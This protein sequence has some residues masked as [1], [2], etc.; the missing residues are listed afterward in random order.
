MSRH[1]KTIE[2]DL[3]SKVKSAVRDQSKFE[4]MR[5]A[6]KTNI[7]SQDTCR[8]K[9]E[10]FESRREMAR[11]SR[12]KVLGDPF[13]LQRTV[14]RLKANRIKV[15]GPCP[16]EE[17]L[18]AVYKELDGEKLV[19]KSK[20]NIT[21]EIG[22]T[23]FLESKG[24]EVIET[25]VGDR[26]IQIAGERTIHP[27][28]PAVHLTRYDIAKILRKHFGR[29]I[30]PDP[31]GLTEAIREEVSDYIM[32][33]KVGVTGANFITAEEGAFVI[34][35]N[36]GNVSL[37]ARR[38]EKH[39]VVS[40]E[41]K[42]VPNLD[43]AM[44]LV[45][46]QTFYGTGSINSSFVDVIAGPSRTADI[47][48]KTFYG[49]HGPKDI[50]LVLVDNGRGLIEDKEIMYCINCGG[51]LL[52]CPVYDLM[53][54][55]FGGHA[56]LGGRGVC[57]TAETESIED[58]SA[59]G[60][61]L[62]TNCGVCTE[63]CP[64]NIDTARIM[65]NTRK[66]ALSAGCLPTEEQRSTLANIRKHGNPW[67]EPRGNRARWAEDLRLPKK[68]ET[69]YF[70][71]CFPS[72]RAPEV[73]KATV[74]VLKAGGVAVAYLGGLESCCGS[75]A[76][77]M[78]DEDLFRKLADQNF[79]EMKRARVKKI[80]TSCAGCYNM[81]SS[82][83]DFIPGF[84]IEVEHITSTL[85]RLVEEGRIKFHSWKAD[86]TY[87]DPCDLG[88]HRGIYEEP[89]S[90]LRAIPDLRIIEMPSNRN[91]SMCCGAGAGVK[92]AYPYL[93]ET[94]AGKRIEEAVGT[95]AKFLVTACAFCEQNFSDA[96]RSYPQNIEVLDL[97]VLARDHLTH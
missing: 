14:D 12:I 82:Y 74:E 65:R 52:R 93:A 62:C 80:I 19:V 42:I 55:E 83:K 48:K 8:S 17:A 43:E 32:R 3:K 70:A 25:D 73:A 90:V 51:C 1:P 78:G 79:E 63:M 29:R 76:L 16:R 27:T 91:L 46:L 24:V 89:R 87:H 35:H 10:G 56:Y 60:L 34:V 37:C 50:V 4:G 92:R 41:E 33:A 13:F 11:A 72:M 86:V 36:E 71:G 77:K 28:G 26:I 18:E 68:G 95:R 58:A 66:K 6:F 31:D 21:K 53:G 94:I 7:H 64:V 67:D 2:F 38:P 23:S 22:L 47:E 59:G 57:F 97:V 54:Y 5:K 75:P 85:S 69:L 96:L 84:E 61:S 9:I 44:N 40:A 88:R 20:S 81:L 49:M 39:I 30:E 45:K 15:I